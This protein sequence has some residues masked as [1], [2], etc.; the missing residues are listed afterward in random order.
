MVS[1]SWTGSTAALPIAGFGG[2]KES[3]EQHFKLIFTI[4]PC[5][6]ISCYVSNLKGFS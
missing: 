6:N 5:V 3:E 1:E 4:L 2:K